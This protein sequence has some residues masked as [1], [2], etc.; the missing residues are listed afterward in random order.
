V[1]TYLNGVD[2][3]GDNDKLSFLL[4][5]QGGDG[6]HTVA[7]GESPLGGGV[8]LTGSASLSTGLEASLLVLLG[9]GPVLVQQTEQL[10]G[11]KTSQE[12]TNIM[13][14]ARKY[15]KAKLIKML[16]YVMLYT[17]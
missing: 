7:D 5:N 13:T 14:E 8:L 11:C 15:T 10:S 4:L 17:S 12:M 2:I 9:L 6:V 1:K 3:I 16:G